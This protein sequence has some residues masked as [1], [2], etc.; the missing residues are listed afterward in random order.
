[1]DLLKSKVKGKGKAKEK[2]KSPSPT[3]LP[4]SNWLALQKVFLH[5][6]L[7]LRVSSMSLRTLSE[8]IELSE[9]GIQ[10]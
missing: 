8:N 1:M 2:E 3:K 4:S 9:R 7:G 5:Q 10:D 6:H